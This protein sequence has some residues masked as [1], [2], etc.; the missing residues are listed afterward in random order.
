MP[1]DKEE[2]FGKKA[3]PIALDLRAELER[4]VEL[5][6]RGF[7]FRGKFKTKTDGRLLYRKQN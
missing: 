5:Q 3:H 7:G 4:S 1:K 2:F 6:E